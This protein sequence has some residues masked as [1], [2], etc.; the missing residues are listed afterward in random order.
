MILCNLA[1]LL[2]ER[3]LKITAVSQDTGLSRTTLTALASNAC[4]GVQFD[5]LNKLCKYLGATPDQMLLFSP[6]DFDVKDAWL[7]GD[8]ADGS[9]LAGVP[10]S[11]DLSVAHNSAEEVFTLNG[12]ARGSGKSNLQTVFDLCVSLSESFSKS[13]PDVSFSVI[14]AQL[15][16]PFLSRLESV[17]L[18]T[19][20]DSS[21]GTSHVTLKTNRVIWL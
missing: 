3:K 8:F 18:A 20:Y 19:G 21:I 5:T 12:E 13:R 7:N 2:A 17:L 4:Q 6:F 14:H 16:R 10:F 11:I 1:V 15:P 9:A